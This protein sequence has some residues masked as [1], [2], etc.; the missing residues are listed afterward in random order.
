MREFDYYVRYYTLILAPF[1]Y[2]KAKHDYK[3]RRKRYG[4]D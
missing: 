1:M 4:Y 2:L 3:V